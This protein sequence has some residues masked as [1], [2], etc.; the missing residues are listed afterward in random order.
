MLGHLMEWFYAG[1]GGINQ[2][3]NSTG[4]RHLLI[5]PQIVGDLGWVK[6]S[7]MTPQGLVKSEW[8]KIAEGL[9]LNLSVPV[10]CKADVI[11]PVKAGQRMFVNGSEVKFKMT[12]GKARLEGL[13]SGNFVLSIR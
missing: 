7:F 11:L 6:T 12:Q 10:N 8:N 2:S 9:E 1:L 5:N 4:F 3:P 13:G